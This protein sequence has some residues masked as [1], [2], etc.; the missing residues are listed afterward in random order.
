M[1]NIYYNDGVQPSTCVRTCRTLEEAKKWISEQLKG[2]T[3]VD[4]IHPCSDDVIASSK[5]A[6]FMVFDGEPFAIGVDGEP[7][8][9]ELVYE[10]D[11]FYTE[12]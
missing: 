8:F 5:T 12:H 10:S 2:Y 3:M 1:M 6:E 7:Y 4:D 11:Y 9:R